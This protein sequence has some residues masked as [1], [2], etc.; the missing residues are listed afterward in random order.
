MQLDAQKRQ[1]D[2]EM[3]QRQIQLDFERQQREVQAEA[4]KRKRELDLRQ[5]ELQEEAELYERQLEKVMQLK[6]KQDE[7][8]NLQTEL[9]LREREEIRADLGSDYDSDSDRVDVTRREKS[10]PK[11]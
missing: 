6:K 11:H 8:E 5:R 9:K 3:R 7:M 4:D 1:E 10:S 2:L